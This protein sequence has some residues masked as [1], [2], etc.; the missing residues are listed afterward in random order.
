MGPDGPKWGQ[1]D[2]CPTNP[3]LA[4][5]LGRT[6]VDFENLY[7]LDVFDSQLGPSLGP[8]LGPS[9][10]LVLQE[11]SCDPRSRTI[12]ESRQPVKQH[13]VQNML[14][15]SGAIFN[16]LFSRCVDNEIV[17]FGFPGPNFCWFNRFGGCLNKID[18]T[19]NHRC[20]TSKE[21]WH[22]FLVAALPFSA[23]TSQWLQQSISCGSHCLNLQQT[24]E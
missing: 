1:E 4:D 8:G 5:I 14:A 20:C 11:M 15:S 6:D 9:L 12:C 22:S 19:C 13:T 18:Q 17:D 16:H 7:F 2:F 3:N 10:G 23:F 24:L 21:L